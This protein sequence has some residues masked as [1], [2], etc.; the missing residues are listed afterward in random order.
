[1]AKPLLSA[2]HH[3]RWRNWHL[4][5][6]VG[7][8][9]QR[10][11]TVRNLWDDGSRSPRKTFKPGLEA[12]KAIVR[13]AESSRRRVRAVGGGW[14][15]SNAAYTDDY[16]VNTTRLTE[17][18]VGF[19]SAGYLE[20]AW[21]SKKDRLVFAQ[22]GVSIRTLNA[23]LQTRNLALMTAGASNGQSIVGA[24]ST[25]THGSANQVGSVQDYVLGLHVVGEQGEDHWIERASNP[26]ASDRFTSWLGVDRVHRDDDLFHAALVSFGS[27]GLIHGVL[28]E[29]EPL[30]LLDRFVQRYDFKDVT[31]ALSTLDVSGLGLPGGDALPFH[32]E[33]VVNPYRLKRG[34]RGAF[35]R[36]LYKR[37]VDVIPP[38]RPSDGQVLNSEDLVSIAGVFS[39]AVPELIPGI[40]QS[41]LEETLPETGRKLVP[42]TPGMQFGDSAPTQ[43]GTS[44]E[45]GVAL[46]SVDE[47]AE[48]IFAVARQHPFGAP[49]AFRFVKSSRAMLAFTRFSPVTCCIELPGIDSARTRIGFEKI[50]D[51][52]HDAGVRHTYHWGQVFPA[53]PDVI[54]RGF[55]SRRTQWL[56]QRA[57]FLTSAGRHT[58]SNAL[59]DRCGLNEP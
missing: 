22:C 57:R 40:L 36:A 46:S 42:G 20:P 52:L 45:V 8:Q 47:A 16:L 53:E 23:H 10:L 34:E 26:V 32:F 48:A 35:V 2:E 58:F 56:E 33:V 15:L 39:D 24:M 4:T 49:V 18:F 51:A 9:V 55:G 44:M 12:L 17:W 29:V 28:F 1:M 6:D 43:G 37:A 14:S 21:H 41:E 5:D 11:Y 38:P 13:D 27:L 19:R 54:S 3:R 59:L 30:Y 7:G 25:G 50:W 31:R